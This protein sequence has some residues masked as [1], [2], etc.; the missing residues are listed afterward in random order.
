MLIF[1]IGSVRKKNNV[2]FQ[3]FR[4]IIEVIS[5]SSSDSEPE[6]M[7][8]EFSLFG[9]FPTKNTSI[10]DEIFPKQRA[11]EMDPR[12]DDEQHM[13]EEKPKKCLIEE[14]D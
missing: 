7:S 1:F 3:V 2:V 4:P 14:L 5:G 11:A 12:A 13:T 10:R 8:P 6:D 9:K